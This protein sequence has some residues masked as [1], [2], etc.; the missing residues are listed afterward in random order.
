MAM[1]LLFVTL[2]DNS[3]HP[4]LIKKIRYFKGFHQ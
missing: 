1:F 4:N 2:L 3:V